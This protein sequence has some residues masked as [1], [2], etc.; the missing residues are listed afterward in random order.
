MPVLDIHVAGV[1]ENECLSASGR[2]DPNP[3]GFLTT[4]ICVEILE[5][6]D[7]VDFNRIGEGSC[8]TVFTGLGEESF[9]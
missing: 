1:T 3:P 5:G 6:T 7:M 4:G 9:F 2:H 8:S